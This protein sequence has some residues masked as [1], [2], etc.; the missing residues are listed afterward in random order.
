MADGHEFQAITDW[1][2]HD[3]AV[4]DAIRAFWLREHANVESDEATRRLT[5]VVAHVVDGNG[6]L[7]A[8]AT[9]TPKVLPRL[10][11]STDNTAARRSKMIILNGND[12]SMRACSPRPRSCTHRAR[13]LPRHSG[14]MAA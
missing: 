6:E 12:G 8:V 1:Q 13:R 9:V 14:S 4:G 3:P 10:G 2:R 11:Q 7:A 5:Q